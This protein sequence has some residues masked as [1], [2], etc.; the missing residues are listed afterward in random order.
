MSILETLA[1]VLAIFG[2]IVAAA[3]TANWL[4]GD[5]REL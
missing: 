1:A 5:N 4:L 2:V 3:L